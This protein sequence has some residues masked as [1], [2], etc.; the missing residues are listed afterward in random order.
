M[1]NALLSSA[2]LPITNDNK[3]TSSL[4]KNIKAII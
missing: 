3:I 1:F 2:R 4:N